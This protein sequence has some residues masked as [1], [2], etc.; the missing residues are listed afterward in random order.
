MLCFYFSRNES[1]ALATCNTPTNEANPMIRALVRGRTQRVNTT[2]PR[3]VDKLDKVV[4]SSMKSLINNKLSPDVTQPLPLKE[5]IGEPSDESEDDNSTL[6]DISTESDSSERKPKKPRKR[7]PW[8]IE[9][10][11]AVLKGVSRFGEGKWRDIQLHYPA[12]K[13]RSNIAVKDAWRLISKN[14]TLL[15]Q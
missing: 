4:N 14:P 15:K 2:F 1:N 8:T 7:I 12:L 5:R 6:S 11:N 9:E 3:T 13:H 10:Y